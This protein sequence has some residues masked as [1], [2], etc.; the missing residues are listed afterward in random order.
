MKV[1]TVDSRLPLR[2]VQ[3]H[4]VVEYIILDALLPLCTGADPRVV[5]PVV[6]EALHHRYL[7]LGRRRA[8]AG[9]LIT[10]LLMPLAMI[11]R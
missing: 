10:L 6:Y 9:N 2:A 3:G 4:Q 5:K 8:R 7:G 11:M 1:T